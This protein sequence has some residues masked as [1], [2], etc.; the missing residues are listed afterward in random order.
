METKQKNQKTKKPYQK[1]RLRV[2]DLVAE[3]VLAVSCKLASGGI[4]NFGNSGP[5]CKA[6]RVCYQVGS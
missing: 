4:R 2:I 3:E 1:P 6:P 5:Q